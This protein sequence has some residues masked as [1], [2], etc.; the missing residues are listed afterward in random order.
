[1]VSWATMIQQP[2]EALDM[3]LVILLRLARVIL[4]TPL[5]IG[6]SMLLVRFSICGGNR[7]LMTLG[8]RMHVRIG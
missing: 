3:S 7:S 1:M 5:L 4:P 6:V 2:H 8:M